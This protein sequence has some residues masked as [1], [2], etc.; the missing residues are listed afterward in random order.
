MSSKRD[1]RF[2]ANYIY[3]SLQ[4]RWVV[5]PAALHPGLRSKSDVAAHVKAEFFFR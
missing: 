3:V 5:V 4:S 2:H 1:F